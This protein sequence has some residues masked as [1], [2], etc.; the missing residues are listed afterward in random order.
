VYTVPIY[1]MA[2]FIFVYVIITLAL[3][4]EFFNDKVNP[5]IFDRILCIYFLIIGG[6]FTVCTGCPMLYYAVTKTFSCL[7]NGLKACCCKPA[8]PKKKKGSQSTLTTESPMA[9]KV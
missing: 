3:A 1:F 7:W 4:W 5:T 8:P 9:A 6:L 2:V